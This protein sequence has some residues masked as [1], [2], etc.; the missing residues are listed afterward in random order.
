MQ[1]LVLGPATC[2]A[3]SL[4]TPNDS[5]D[6]QWWERGE[7]SWLLDSLSRTC[8]HGSNCITC[9]LQVADRRQSQ[10]LADRINRTWWHSGRWKFVSDWPRLAE[11]KSMSS[12]SSAR[13]AFPPGPLCV[14]NAEWMEM[15]RSRRFLVRLEDSFGCPFEHLLLRNLG[16]SLPASK[17]P[18][19]T[20]AGLQRC[21]GLQVRGEDSHR[22]WRDWWLAG[23][24]SCVELEPQRRF[25]GCTDRWMQDDC[26]RKYRCMTGLQATILTNY[27][28]DVY[29]MY[30][31]M[32]YVVHF[33]VWRVFLQHLPPLGKG[34]AER[35]VEPRS[36]KGLAVSWGFQNHQQKLPACKRGI[37][38]AFWILLGVWCFPKDISG[39]A[40]LGS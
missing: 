12:R 15:K 29:M 26:G 8:E 21:C 20:V 17:L 38:W 13:P 32:I 33:Q 24:I 1:Y 28:Y 2:H 25:P 40:Y 16:A 23:D 3:L 22:S 19:V 27:I 11:S 7:Q 30:I 36:Q 14:W 4:W 9:H 10:I 39:V 34:V 31:Y 18:D 6:T 37:L 35:H 5:G